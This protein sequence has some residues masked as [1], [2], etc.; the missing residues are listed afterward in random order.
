[1]YRIIILSLA[2]IIFYVTPSCSNPKEENRQNFACDICIISDS[3]I[4]LT[5]RQ[6]AFIA[7]NRDF[8]QDEIKKI[9][10]NLGRLEKRL[11]EL[12]STINLSI[13]E[14]CFICSENYGFKIDTLKNKLIKTYLGYNYISVINPENAVPFVNCRVITSDQFEVRIDD[15]THVLNKVQ[16]EKYNDEIVRKKMKLFKYIESQKVIILSEIGN[17]KYNELNSFEKYLL[18]L[19]LLRLVGDSTFSEYIENDK[20]LSELNERIKHSER[21]LS[22]VPD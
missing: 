20:Y 3:I 8:H 18:E 6:I 4:N 10:G 17:L 21:S 15:E 19:H 14:A 12:R 22:G 9:G 5:N 7:T 11:N 13:D 16:Y 2:C 1:M